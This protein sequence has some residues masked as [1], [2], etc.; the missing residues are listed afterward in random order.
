MWPGTFPLTPDATG[1]RLS[2]FTS[3]GELLARFGGGANPCATGDF[4]APHAI[5]L[6]SHGDFYFAEVIRSACQNVRPTMGDYHTLQKFTRIS[7]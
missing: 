7:K 4:F 1:G 5:W 3:T 6:D 2:I